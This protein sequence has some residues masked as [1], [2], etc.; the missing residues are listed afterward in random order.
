LLVTEDSGDVFARLAQCTG[1]QWDAGNTGKVRMRHNVAPGE[2]EQAFFQEP[3][4]VVFDERHS[5]KEPRWHALGQTLGGRP[6]HLVFTLRGELIRVI[7]ARDMN[8]K[9]RTLYAEA[10]ADLEANPDL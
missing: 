6:L 1:F 4:L 9:E 7:A 5:G 3:F 10:K 2:C 8:R